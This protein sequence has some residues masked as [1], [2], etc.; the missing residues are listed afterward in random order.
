VGMMLS[1]LPNRMVFVV[2]KYV[3]NR[4]R[5]QYP[6]VFWTVMKDGFLRLF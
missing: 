5:Q 1:S 3:K 6:E 2:K 4:I